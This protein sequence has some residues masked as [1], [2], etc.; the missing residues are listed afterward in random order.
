MGSVKSKPKAPAPVVSAPVSTSV[1]AP[2]VNMALDPEV[3][4]AEARKSSLLARDRGRFGTILTSF[5]GFLAQKESAP[6]RKTLLG[7]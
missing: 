4:A 3:E 6:Q 2:V 7:E 5:R 1:A